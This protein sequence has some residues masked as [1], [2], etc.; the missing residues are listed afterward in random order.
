[1]FPGVSTSKMEYWRDDD[2]S[3]LIPAEELERQGILPLGICGGWADEH[4]TATSEGKS[5]SCATLVA[6]RLGV[7]DNPAIKPLL[8]YVENND[9]K[10]GRRPLDLADAMNALN[11]QFPD[12]PEKVMEW[13]M[14]A[15]EAKYQQ[16]LDF[17]IASKAEFE[18]A[19]QVEDVDI[20]GPDCAMVVRMATIVSD[21]EQVAK[22]ARSE[23]GCGAAVV[24]QKQQSSGNVQIFLDGQMGLNLDDIACIIR[25]EE[26]KLNGLS[27]T[28]EWE[29]LRGEGTIEGASCWHYLKKDSGRGRPKIGV[30]LLNGSLGHPGVPPTKIPLERIQEIVRIGLNPGA[31]EPGRAAECAKGNCTSTANNSCLWYNWGLLRCR[32]IRFRMRQR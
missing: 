30:A 1:M 2:P 10:G 15:I 11:A 18:R 24:I 20:E 3:M 13:A 4:A 31:F 27:S 17:L 7:H 25:S 16:Q 26:K 14:M 19:A 9:K 6:K 21:D 29:L 22:F 5:G 32:G 23:N 8:R 28:T 12:N